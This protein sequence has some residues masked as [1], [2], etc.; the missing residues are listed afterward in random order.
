MGMYLSNKPSN[1]DTRRI[2][3]AIFEYSRTDDIEVSYDNFYL[4][5]Y[6][7]LIFRA[8]KVDLTFIL[9]FFEKAALIYEI[10][11]GTG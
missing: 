11:Q 7:Y 10:H 4:Y 2:V 3:E 1:L 5:Y 9:F 8:A 6:S